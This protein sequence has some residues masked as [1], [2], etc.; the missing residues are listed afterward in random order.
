MR[1]LL[2]HTQITFLPTGQWAALIESGWIPSYLYTF[3]VLFIRGEEYFC[4]LY[5]QMMVGNIFS[6]MHVCVKKIDI[7][8]PTTALQSGFRC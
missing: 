8:Y 2:N 3:F 7:G 1:V 4:T 6:D 5:S